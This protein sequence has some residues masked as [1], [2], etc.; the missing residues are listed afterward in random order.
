MIN[1]SYFIRATR[2]K[3]GELV[4]HSWSARSSVSLFP[5][6]VGL[7]AEYKKELEEAHIGEQVMV[8]EFRRV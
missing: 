8:E 3:G 5:N 1:R 7:L 2:H 4:G 6:P